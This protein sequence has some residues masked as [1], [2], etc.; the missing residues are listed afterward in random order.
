MADDLAALRRITKRR[1]RADTEWRDE[2]CRQF[3][4]GRSLREIAAAAG[5]SHVAV[6]KIVR[7][8]TAYV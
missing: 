4:E 2:I 8:R 3:A 5:V 1:S 6:L 7:Q